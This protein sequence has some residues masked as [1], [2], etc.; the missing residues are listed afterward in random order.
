MRTWRDVARYHLVVPWVILL[1]PWAILACSFIV[2]LVIFSR[3]PVADAPHNDTGGVASIYVFFFV[4]GVSIV[5]RSLPFGLALSVSR[6]SYYAGSAALG[7]ALAVADG[8]ALAALQAIERATG[9]WGESMHFFWLPYILDGPWY[10]TWLTS[11]VGLV[12]LFAYGMWFAIVYR[13]WRL[14]GTLT[15]I[16]AQITVLLAVAAAITLAHAWT[17]FERFFPALTAAGVTGL[18]AAL[19][20]LLLTGGYATIRRI[21]V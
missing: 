12:L 21:T 17:G 3:V 7:V 10:I 2:N 11:F 15:F 13:R 18:L 9:G 1:M 14:I 5:G 8:L 16:A 6:R 19:A 20:A 4:I